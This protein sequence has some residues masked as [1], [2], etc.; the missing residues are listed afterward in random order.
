MGRSYLHTSC[1]L[2]G[3]SSISI[4]CVQNGPLNC[5]KAAQNAPKIAILRLKMENFSWEGDPSPSERG[6]PLP[7]PRSRAIRRSRLDAS[8]RSCGARS[9]GASSFLEVWLRPKIIPLATALLYLQIHTPRFTKSEPFW[10]GSV[11]SVLEI[12]PLSAS[13]VMCGMEV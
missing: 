12:L 3:L 9:L 11:K 5:K 13:A 4:I 8:I 1:A 7:I 2:Y 10:L 6:H